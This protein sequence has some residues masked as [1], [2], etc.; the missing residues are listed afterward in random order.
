MLAAALV[1]LHAARVPVLG[2]R[3]AGWCCVWEAPREA[4]SAAESGAAQLLGARLP[5]VGRKV[6]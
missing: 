6:A 4:V 2:P 3:P 5:A 1:A